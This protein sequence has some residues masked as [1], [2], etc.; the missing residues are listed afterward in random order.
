MHGKYTHVCTLK[1]TLYALKTTPCAWY[2]RI[3]EY[4]LK[5]GFFKTTKYSNL[6][7]LYDENDL[8]VLVLYIDVLIL[9]PRMPNVCF[10]VN[11]SS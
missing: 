11:T 5:M 6:H 4:I 2:S 8:L 10:V 7:Y 1:K 9:V 3:E